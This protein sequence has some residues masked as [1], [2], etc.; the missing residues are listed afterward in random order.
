M[1][2]SSDGRAV[3]VLRSGAVA[4]PPVE[5]LTSEGIA[6]AVNVRIGE[7]VHL[8]GI[9]TDGVASLVLTERGGQ[10]SAVP[11]ADNFFDV[12]L[13]AWPHALNWIGPQGPRSLNLARHEPPGTPR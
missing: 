7:P 10:R 3:C 4:C 13:D 11:I 6:P 9:A 2:P 8:W 1:A 12:E 5:V